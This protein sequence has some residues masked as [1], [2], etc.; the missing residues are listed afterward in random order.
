MKVKF[1]SGFV[2]G[3]DVIEAKNGRILIV[4]GP[5]L[6]SPTVAESLQSGGFTK[7]AE[8]VSKSGLYINM[9]A[10]FNQTILAPTDAAFNSANINITALAPTQA[11]DLLLSHIVDG[12]FG[13]D[14]IPSDNVNSS[15][16]GTTHN[17]T[18]TG[19]ITVDAAVN[20]DNNNNVFAKSASII[21]S[22]S[23]VLKPVGWPSAPLISEILAGYGL[24]GKTYSL[25]KIAD[26]ASTYTEW[27]DEGLMTSLVAP[28]DDSN[29]MNGTARPGIFSK[30]GT[31]LLSP[32][33]GN[34]GI[35][36]DDR[37]RVGIEWSKLHCSISISV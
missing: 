18:W 7:F 12:F 11:R 35:H 13:T 28:T 1:G 31:P 26:V 20:F 19:Q 36:Q 14:R 24:E 21:H 32:S 15:L 34:F 6:D 23:D 22:L 8:L 10:V 30:K 33:S 37:F 9:S 3:I 16:T 5:I 2:S 29:T 4:D 25:S 17:F 27:S